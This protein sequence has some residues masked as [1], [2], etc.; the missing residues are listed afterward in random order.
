VPRPAASARER[1]VIEIMF[2]RALS[3]TI[4]SPTRFLFDSLATM[5]RIVRVDAKSIPSAG[6]SYA[7]AVGIFSYGGV[8]FGIGR[9]FLD[10]ADRLLGG[11]TDAPD[12]LYCRAVGFIHHFLAGDWS[13]EHEVPDAVLEEKVRAGRLWEVVTY[14]GFL[15]EKQIR[16]G[17]FA[18]AAAQ[19]ERCY[20]L[21]EGFE[22]PA[23][24]QAAKGY[25]TYL[26]LE[27]GRPGEAVSAADDY[28]EESPQELPHLVALAMRAE[29]QLRAGE[30][31]AATESLAR[32]EQILAG[33][34][35]G[36]TIPYHLSFHRSARYHAE[37][38]ALEQGAGARPSAARLRK[39][40]RAALASVRKMAGAAP[41]VFR[42][43]GRE[44]WLRGRR[45]RASDWWARSLAAAERLGTRPETA[46][47]L[48]ELGLR[49]GPGGQAPDGRRG[50]ECLAAAGRLYAE[51]R[52]END[53]ARLGRGEPP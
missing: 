3:Q 10:E 45:D 51:L 41:A 26:L 5:R 36:T 17:E 13:A 34:S 8:S 11:R 38:T 50:E 39:S 18:G 28:Y 47:T 2:Q 27:Q 4:A 42:L 30:L 24:K 23:A 16:R 32:G 22:Y 44:A 12:Y 29:A 6:R 31:A 48:H 21:A 1:E 33:M 25:Q 9:R 37:L 46:R 35:V 49:I 43:V 20:A 19:I 14:L 15:A 52:L 40:R 53:L 7:G